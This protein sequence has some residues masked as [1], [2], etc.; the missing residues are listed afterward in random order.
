MNLTEEEKIELSV[1]KARNGRTWKSKLR[2]SWE[3]GG[4]VAG[5]HATVLYNLR[6]SARF[7]P[8]GL[9]RLK[10]KDLALRLSPTLDGT[11]WFRGQTRIEGVVVWCRW[12]TVGICT[13]QGQQIVVARDWRE[14]L[15]KLYM[16]N[17][18]LGFEIEFKHIER[19]AD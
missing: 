18:A 17:T 8:T 16:Q 14:K 11:Y 5:H 12:E 1:F 6:N 19:P 7:G 9:D 4:V 13:D 15:S 2:E 10:E 3:N